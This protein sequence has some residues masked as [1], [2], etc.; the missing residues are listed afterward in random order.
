MSIYNAIMKAADYI[1]CH[2]KKFDFNEIA[3]PHCGS[4]GCA[5]GWIGYFLGIQGTIEG[6]CNAGISDSHFYTAMD[7]LVGDNPA[8]DEY[9]LKVTWGPWH[10]DAA[11]CARGMRLYAAKYHAPVVVPD[12]NALA[13]V[14]LQEAVNV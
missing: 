12:W 9:G 3:I 4:P 2:P 1:E 13:A 6:V 14:P 5:L 11:I 7:D 8:R 10:K